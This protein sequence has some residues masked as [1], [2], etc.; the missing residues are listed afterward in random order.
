MMDRI[1]ILLAA[2]CL[3]AAAQ[4]RLVH[5]DL[6]YQAPGNK[7]AP[8]FSPYGTPVQLTDLPPGTPVPEGALRPA[9]TGTLQVG[10]ERSSWIRIL[11]TADPA[12]PKDWSRLYI[13]RNR[14]GDF[15]DD[16]PPLTAKPA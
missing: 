7:P 14:N 5:V 3:A 1:G 10:P 15:S 4:D 13:D 8:N 16:G 6:A 11:V 2:G 12:S 9:R